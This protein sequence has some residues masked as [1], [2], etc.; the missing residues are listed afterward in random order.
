MAGAAASAVT[1]VM[2]D[3][4][5]GR[6]TFAGIRPRLACGSATSAAATLT[7]VTR[8]P[9]SR[10]LQSGSVLP[11]TLPWFPLRFGTISCNTLQSTLVTLISGASPGL[12]TLRASVRHPAMAWQ[13]ILRLR[14]TVGG[15]FWSSQ[16]PNLHHLA[17]YTAQPVSKRVPKPLASA[18]PCAMATLQ[19]WSSMPTASRPAKSAT[20]DAIGALRGPIQPT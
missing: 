4:T 5:T 20:I 12:S 3:T 9:C 1:A 2:Q 18:A 17:P 16:P 11:V 14:L 8:G 15:P 10:V 13:T 19:T 7:S 6:V